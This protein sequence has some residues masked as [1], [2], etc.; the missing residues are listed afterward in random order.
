MELFN[1][2]RKRDI[3]LELGVGSAETKMVFYVFNEPVYNTFSEKYANDVIIT[4]KGINIIKKVPVHVSRLDTILDKYCPIGT[5]I[6]FFTIDTE[7][8][9]FDVIK[10]NDW[11]KYRPKIV[12]LEL[13]NMSIESILSSDLHFFMKKIGYYF[14]SKCFDSLFYKRGE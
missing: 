11:E 3:N 13:Q 4:R 8:L 12:L 6:D 1:K 7:T 10:S 14:Y 5:E 9:D 2:F